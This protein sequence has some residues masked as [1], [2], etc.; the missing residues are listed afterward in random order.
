MSENKIGDIVIEKAETARAFWH[1]LDGSPDV[2]LCA[3]NL[4]TYDTP[5]SVR[6][7]FNNLAAAVA[8]NLNRT[9]GQTV[10]VQHVSPVQPSEAVIDRKNFACWSC[11]SPVAADARAYLGAFSDADLATSMTPQGN[12]KFCCRVVQ[13]GVF[14]AQ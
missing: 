11:Q 3:V 7:L 13:S 5:P 10:T 12:L 4:Y 8:V 14:L 2:L 9:V 1:P 6:E